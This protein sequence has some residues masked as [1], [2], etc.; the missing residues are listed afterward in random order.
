MEAREITDSRVAE[1]VHKCVETDGA[2]GHRY[3]G[4]DALP[5]VTRGPRTGTLP[6]ETA[7]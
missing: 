5:L 1:H 7:R 6:T 3:Q 2:S 4:K